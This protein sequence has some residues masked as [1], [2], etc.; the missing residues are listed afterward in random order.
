MGE[1]MERRMPG[2][3]EEPEPSTEGSG[4]SELVGGEGESQAEETQ[5][6]DGK[7]GSTDKEREQALEKLAKWKLSQPLGE[8]G[9]MKHRMTDAE[10]KMR[11][12]LGLPTGKRRRK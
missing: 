6:V 8:W 5:P 2:E 9:K 1:R 10:R 12:S 7:T 3:G 4:E 11:A